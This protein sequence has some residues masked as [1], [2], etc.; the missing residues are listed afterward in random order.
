MT[1]LSRHRK[2][3]VITVILVFIVA[4]FIVGSLLSQPLPAPSNNG[5][6]GISVHSLSSE[7]ANLVRDS[8]AEWV[9]I[10]V[11]E[12]LSNFNASMHNAKASG[13]SV[14]AILDSWMFDRSTAF[15]LDEWQA[16]VTYYVSQYANYVDAW[17]IWNEPAHPS[18]PLLY[19]DLNYS[20]PNYEAN[21]QRIVEFYYSMTRTA[22]DIIKQ[23]D[24]DSTILLFGGVHLWA[25]G[26]DDPTLALDK[27]F[28]SRA[29]AKGIFEYGD[30]IAVHAYPWSGTPTA[31]VWNGY[32]DTIGYYRELIPKNKSMEF[33]VTE[34]GQ[35]IND[36]GEDG[37]G[38]YLSDALGYFQ[39]RVR[40]LFWYSL[41][42]NTIL[43]PDEKCFGLI[44]NGTLPRPAYIELKDYFSLKK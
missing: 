42:D 32:T 39:G 13:L 24:P 11:S 35:S 20:H 31:S 33:W 7:D 28:Y 10:D 4:S 17:E 21:M 18:Y 37:Q 2:T 12:E 22:H 43:F 29:A 26:G 14:L 9:R 16:N 6:F 25:G 40:H 23:Y 27:D 1:W 38:Q 34:T 41:H 44:A 19:V 30:A 36:S 5:Y 15:T 3:W 8:G